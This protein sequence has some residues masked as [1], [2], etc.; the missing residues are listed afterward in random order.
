MRLGLKLVAA[1]GSQAVTVPA[2]RTLVVGRSPACD[3]PIRDLTVSRHHGEV[4]A[5]AAGLRVRD[6]GSTNGTFINGVRISEGVAAPGTRVAFGKVTFQVMEERATG[7]LAESKGDAEGARLAIVDQLRA[8]GLTDVATLLVPEPAAAAAGRSL[9]VGGVIPAERRAAALALLLETAKELSQQGDPA[10]LLD[11]A[12]RLLLQALRVDRVDILTRGDEDE[13]VPRVSKARPGAHAGGGQVPHLAARK[14]GIERLAVLIAERAP[15]DGTD[16]IARGTF[17]ADHG[18]PAGSA[19]AIAVPAGSGAAVNG[20]AGDSAGGTP[21]PLEAPATDAL[22]RTG[23]GQPVPAAT[24]DAV[25]IAPRGTDGGQAAAAAGAPSTAGTGGGAA[26][27]AASTAVEARGE[28][29]CAPLLGM[30]ATALGLL[31]VAAEAGALGREDLEFVNA[32]AGVLAVTLENLQLMERARGEAVAQA[33]YQ[34]HFAPFVA[35]QI[36]GQNGVRLDG[37]R[38]QVAFLCCDLRGAAKLAEE[39]PPEEAAR[40][41]REIFSELV[42]VVFEHGGTLDRLAGT[43]LTALWGAPLGRQDDADEAVQA[44]MGMQRGLERLNA[45]WSRQQRRRLDLAIGI[46]IGQ[47]FAGSI[48]S[49]RRLE[50][51]AIGEPVGRSSAL[52]AAAGPG[53]IRVSSGLLEA[54][55]SPPPSD[56]IADAGTDASADAS[57]DTSADAAGTADE[58]GAGPAAAPGPAAARAYRIDWRTPPTLRQSGEVPQEI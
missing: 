42:D 23:S 47:V 52:C 49:D 29:I 53:E 6:L 26:T 22:P 55:S 17:T 3:V 24:T 13:M 20:A 44:A 25:H 45:E 32:F 19:G 1:N 56:A 27:T 16:A 8:Q 7:A 51:T 38:R 12:A 14:A 57:A 33:G 34:R 21:P 50:Y 9:R 39:L 37:D 11:K 36:A 46:D 15:A 10:R 48:G 2:G 31:Y 58:R 41:L 43:G 5:A 30:Q 4:E 18:A 54:L 40:Q 28:A 35:D